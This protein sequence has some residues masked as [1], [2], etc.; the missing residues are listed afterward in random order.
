MP[1]PGFYLHPSLNNF[2]LHVYTVLIKILQPPLKIPFIGNIY[3][4]S[5]CLQETNQTKAI[6]IIQHNESGFP[7]FNW[8]WNFCD[9]YSPQ[10]TGI[11]PLNCK[12]IK[13]HI[14]KTEVFSG[15]PGATNEELY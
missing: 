15:T 1:A 13:E 9:F 7:K 8:K 4:H 2:I 12:I 3:K 10:I 5:S 14:W 11:Q 6:K